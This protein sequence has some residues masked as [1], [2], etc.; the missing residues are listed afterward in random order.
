MNGLVFTRFQ[1]W[2]AHAVDV[3]GMAKAEAYQSWR[4]AWFTE[5]R[6]IEWEDRRTG[7]KCGGSHYGDA[8]TLTEEIAG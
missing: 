6:G 7:I 1:D 2:M 8:S 4:K 5:T 3:L